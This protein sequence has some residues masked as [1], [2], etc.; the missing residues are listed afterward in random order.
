MRQ[1]LYEPPLVWQLEKCFI[2]CFHGNHCQGNILTFSYIT[3][4]QLIEDYILATVFLKTWNQ[5][6]K[7]HSKKIV[8]KVCLL[9]I[10]K[11]RKS[12]N[13]VKMQQKLLFCVF[14]ITCYIPQWI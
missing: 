7:D 4:M 6:G 8:A 13:G 1:F 3:I 9:P 5:I 10:A 14:P 12:D 11:D 2:F